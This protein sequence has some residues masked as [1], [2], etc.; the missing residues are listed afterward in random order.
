MTRA[1]VVF[2]FD[3]TGA[4]YAKY[5]DS[6]YYSDIEHTPKGSRI[7]NLLNWINN[8]PKNTWRT[9]VDLSTEKKKLS[10]AFAISRNMFSRGGVKNK[11]RFITFSRSNVTTSIN[12]AT[13]RFV[14]YLSEQL[15][16]EIDRQ[17]FFK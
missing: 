5:L 8:K 17:I 14:D 10:F 9:S 12:K 13:S 11:S 3:F 7:N 6:V 4:G 2:E 15:A 16:I 1:T